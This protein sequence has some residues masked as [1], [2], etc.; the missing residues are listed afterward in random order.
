MNMEFSKTSGSR[1]ELDRGIG[2]ILKYDGETAKGQAMRAPF[3]ISAC[4]VPE[5]VSGFR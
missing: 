3:K 1:P 4:P 2:I 5:A